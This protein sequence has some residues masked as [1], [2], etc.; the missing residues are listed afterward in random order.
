MIQIKIQTT[1]E[2]QCAKFHKF[3]PVQNSAYPNLGTMQAVLLTAIFT[4]P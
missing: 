4:Q 2:K 1:S 3:L